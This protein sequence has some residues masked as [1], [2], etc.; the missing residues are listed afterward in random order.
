MALFKKRISQEYK[1]TFLTG[2]GQKVLQHMM[3]KYGVYVPTFNDEANRMYFNE[4]QRN[5]VLDILHY[6][7]I[8]EERARQ[9]ALA[10]SEEDDGL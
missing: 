10:Q 9:I 1:D 6:L 8:D 3:L 4:G 2:P 7:S 5:V